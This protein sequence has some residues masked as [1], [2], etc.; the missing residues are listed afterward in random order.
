VLTRGAPGTTTQYLSL[1]IYRIGFKFS[2]LGQASALAVVVM[3]AMILF[4]TIVSR[5]LPADRG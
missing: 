2:E 1:Y 5:F 3:V 4:Y